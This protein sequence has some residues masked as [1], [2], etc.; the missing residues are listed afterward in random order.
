MTNGGTYILY[1]A[2]PPQNGLPGSVHYT[3][4]ITPSGKG[5]PPTFDPPLYLYSNTK[6]DYQA[7]TGAL[8]NLTVKNLEDARSTT[9]WVKLPAP[10][11]SPALAQFKLEQIKVNGNPITY[12]YKLQQVQV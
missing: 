8:K 5:D 3:L 2:Y 11:D 6:Q 4:V 1:I 12:E 10:F 9:N 7:F